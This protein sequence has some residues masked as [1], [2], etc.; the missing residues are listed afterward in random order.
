MV[1]NCPVNSGP[2]V[3]VLMSTFNRL[4][5]VSEAIESVLRQDYKNFELIVVRDGGAELGEIIGKYQDKRL[6]FIDRDEN[7]GK[8]YSLN[9]AIKRARGKYVCYL[10]DDDI[11]YP[12]HIRVL[13]E[14]LESQD[15]CS[16]AYSDLYKAHCRIEP[17]GRRTV[18]SK[19]VEVSRDFNRTVMLQ[20]NHVLHVSLMHRRDLF[21]KTGLYNEKI[22][23]LVDWDMIR[24]LA[25][26]TDFKHIYDVT[27]EFYAPVGDCDR[28]SI[29]RRKS[30][31]NYIWNVLTIRSTRPAK[32]WPKVKD[33]SVI[34][35]ANR[36][37]GQVE[38]LIRDIWSHSYYPHQIYLPLPEEDLRR[39]KTIV[40]NVVGVSVSAL[41]SANERVDKALEYCQGDYVAVV[42]SSFKIVPSDIAWVEK[43]LEPLKVSED[44][45]EAFE[46][47]GEEGNEWSAV[48]HREQIEKARR[49]H[50]DLGVRES[51]LAAGVRI[52]KPVKEEFPFQF[53]NIFLG[54]EMVEKEGEWLQA[55]GI[56]EY[57]RNNYQNDLWMNT[58]CA[59]ALYYAGKY[60]RAAEIAARLNRLRPTVATLLVEARAHHKKEEY[61]SAL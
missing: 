24:R 9:Q 33:L 18:L 38:Q 1:S 14:A 48:F 35:V 16:V 55:F 57:L 60:S 49:L 20:F 7:K 10:D 25:F 28:I 29:Q 3:S 42:P 45:F 40:P 2:L 11:Y 44:P 56:F 27:G 4:R 22:N 37:N 54:A 43:S 39:L 31:Q 19:N 15:E 59:N 21:E 52:R 6:I 41:S 50:G 51:V 5:Y 12:H 13:V 36:L 8:A 61:D 17:D 32:P 23:V 53:G 30:S 34:I 46:I 47:L 26:F 58:K